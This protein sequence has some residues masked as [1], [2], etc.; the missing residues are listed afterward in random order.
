[1]AN[2]APLHLFPWNLILPC[3][4]SIGVEFWRFLL[5]SLSGKIQ[6]LINGW[7]ALIFYVCSGSVVWHVR[8]L[9]ELLGEKK[10]SVLNLIVAEWRKG[11]SELAEGFKNP[12]D[13]CPS[14]NSSP[15]DKT[16]ASSHM[17]IIRHFKLEYSLKNIWFRGRKKCYSPCSLICIFLLFFPSSASSSIICNI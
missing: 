10:S 2:S 9:V 14:A 1:M 6:L 7:I 17:Q 3:E 16:L 4:N 13:W 15:G 5:L 12:T 8:L 11:H